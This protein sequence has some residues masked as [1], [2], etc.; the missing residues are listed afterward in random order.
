MCHMR[1]ERAM[2][3]WLYLSRRGSIFDTS[4]ISEVPVATNCMKH[5]YG[6]QIGAWKPQ[7]YS[8]QKLLFRNI[9]PLVP[10]CSCWSGVIRGLYSI[11]Q[12]KTSICTTKD[13]QRSA[14]GR[15]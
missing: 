13:A 6:W 2:T 3:S 7:L 14:K 11:Q 15:A 1:I 4:P 5:N 10:V 9:F 8:V 12:G